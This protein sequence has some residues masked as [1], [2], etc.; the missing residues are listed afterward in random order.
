MKVLY[1]D[2]LAAPNAKAN[3]AGMTKAYRKLATVHTFD[4]RSIAKKHGADQMN[5]RLVSLAAAF[6]PDFIHLGKCES[7]KGWAISRIKKTRPKTKVIHFFGDYRNKVIPWV[8]DIGRACDRTVM[9]I[10][11]GPLV[12]AYE[13]AG[14]KRVAYWPAGTDPDIYRPQPAVAKNLNIVFMGT[15]G[16]PKVF[17]WYR[18]RR[19]L[20]VALTKN[21][22]I[23]VFGGGWNKVKHPRVRHHKYVG[24]SG[25]SDAC[26][27]ATIALGYGAADVPGYTSWP[28]VLNSMVCGCFFL[29]RHFTGLE[30]TFKRGVHLDWFGSIPEAV[31]KVD[32][33]QTHAKKRETIAKQGREE[34]LRAHTWDHRI[35]TMLRYAGFKP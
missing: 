30:K 32:Y 19:D 18:G 1:V 10:N 8:V 15:L 5:Q 13:A 6:K 4:Y 7:I 3:V 9:Q 14:C 11:G 22:V 17:P 33:Y 23:N 26:S 28:R 2:A 12:K 20:V 25:F 31:K 27:R 34:V 16:N 21:N 24:S 35:R 29:T